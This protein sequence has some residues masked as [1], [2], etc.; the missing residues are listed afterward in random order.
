[1]SPETIL[2]ELQKFSGFIMNYAVTLAAVGAITMALLEAAKKLLGTRPRFHQRAVLNWLQREQFEKKGPAMGIL[3]IR[4]EGQY[5]M[6]GAAGESTAPPDH[7][8]AYQQLMHLT[9]GLPRWFDAPV[10]YDQ[11][12]IATALFEQELD[13]MMA[14]VQDAAD[15]VLNNPA[16]YP[17][18]FAFLTSSA[19]ESDAETWKSAMA[20]RDGDR[21]QLAEIH[22][23]L[24]LLMKRQLDSFQT[25]TGFR[26]RE[27][28][29]L[30]AMVV[31]AVLLFLA[32]LTTPSQSRNYFTMVLVSVLG[33]ILAP[34]AKDL[35]DALSKA[36]KG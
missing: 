25:V 33:G 30:W 31:G 1:M 13:V 24:R 3:P 6:L 36:K 12:N 8:A 29:Q 32:Q 22:S 15:A 7:R 35:V 14:Q 23:R 4:L 26:W 20:T 18:L 16:L 34:V 19:A 2:A 5:G 21:G 28:N 27:V 11:R 10:K 9:T 17:E